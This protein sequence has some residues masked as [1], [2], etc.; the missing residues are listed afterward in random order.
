MVL[1]EF[2]CIFT[3][4]VSVGDRGHKDPQCVTTNDVTATVGD[5]LPQCQLRFIVSVDYWWH[6]AAVDSH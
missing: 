5:V 3:E 1:I 2:N 6:K 4:S